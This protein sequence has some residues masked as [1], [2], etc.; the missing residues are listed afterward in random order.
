MDFFWHAF[1]FARHILLQCFKVGWTILQ[2]TEFSS[3]LGGAFFGA[4]AA[5][6]FESKR[7]RREKRDREYE[8]LLRTQAVIISQGNSLAW[9]AKLYP[10]DDSFNN[11]QTVVLGFTRQMLDFKDLAFIAKSS[12]PQ[13]LIDLDVANER[14]DFFRR[15]LESRN[16]TIQEFLRHPETKITNLDVTT[17]KFTGSGLQLLEF[18]VRQT[19]SAA[20]RSLANAKARQQRG[21]AVLADVCTKGIPGTTSSFSAREHTI[22]GTLSAC[23][24]NVSLLDD[25]TAQ[26]TEVRTHLRQLFRRHEY[27]PDTKTFLLRAYVDIA[28]EHHDAIWLLA[29]CRL[30]GSA[31]AM[32]RAVYDAMFRAF[33]INLPWPSNSRLR[34]NLPTCSVFRQT[35]LY[36]G[37][38]RRQIAV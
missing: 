30:N 36:G 4:T 10:S 3:A 5:A 24:R 2:S 9:I 18:N 20:S 34:S 11:Y 25:I 33:W 15:L 14:Y 8:A 35:A 27:P 21:H 23:C 6:W 12:D 31:F 38:N 32:V 1:D 26:G 19:N 7:R 22:I 17:G 37:R 28:F 29:K 16:A 13:L